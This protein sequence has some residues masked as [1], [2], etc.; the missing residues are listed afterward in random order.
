MREQAKNK[1][2]TGSVHV[3]NGGRAAT[4]LRRRSR[5]PEH[6]NNPLSGAQPTL[7]TAPCSLHL[8]SSSIFPLHPHPSVLLTPSST[9]SSHRSPSCLSSSSASSG[10][11]SRYASVPSSPSTMT[12]L[13][14]CPRCLR[15]LPH[16][17]THPSRR[18]SSPSAFL[19]LFLRL[20][21]SSS[22]RSSSSPPALVSLGHNALCRPPARRHG[23]VPSSL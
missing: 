3:S 6:S 13:A 7:H 20:A 5:P 11:L 23:W 17:M 10:P 9:S 21:T 2:I 8:Q 12:F 22:S 15:L 18:A 14:S 16:T 4:A 1:G 19:L